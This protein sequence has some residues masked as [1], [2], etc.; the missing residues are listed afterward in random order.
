MNGDGNRLI[1]MVVH[2]PAM[3]QIGPHQHKIPGS[4]HGN[5]ST[6]KPAATSTD[7]EIQFIVLMRMDDIPVLLLIQLV[8]LERMRLRNNNSV[9]DKLHRCTI[10]NDRIKIQYNE[11]ND[12]KYDIII[13][14]YIQKLFTKNIL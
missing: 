11:N 5:I 2:F 1:I 4:V 12:V 10:L 14:I 13:Y 7:N 8:D 9:P 6:D 3:R